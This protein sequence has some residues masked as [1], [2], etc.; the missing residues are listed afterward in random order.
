MTEIAGWVSPKY[1]AVM[2]KVIN[3]LSLASLSISVGGLH[4]TDWLI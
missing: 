1:A 4:I 3:G 2:G